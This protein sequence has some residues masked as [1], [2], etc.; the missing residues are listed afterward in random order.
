MSSRLLLAVATVG[1][2]SV[3]PAFAEVVLNRGNVAEPGTLDPQKYSTTYE[4]EISHELFEGLLTVGADAKPVP[5]GAESWTVSQDGRI[6]TFKLRSG[7]KWS[8]GK[9][10]TAND[11]VYGIRRGLDPATHGWYGNLAYNIKNA[12]RVNKGELP[13]TALGVTAPDANTVVIELNHPSPI[14]FLLLTLP[15]MAAAPKH[16]IDLHP[17]DWTKPGTMVSNGAYTL[18]EWRPNDHIKLLRNPNFHDAQH[19][20]IDVVNYYPTDDDAAAVKRLRAGELD[21]N[22]RFPPNEIA[23]LRRILPTGTLHTS[24]SIGVMYL[25]PNLKKTPFADPR[26]RRALSLAIDRESIVGQ[27]LRNGEL[28]D[29]SLAPPTVPGYTQAT[30]GF[31]G[32][33]LADRQAE[34]RRLLAQA[35]YTPQHP[36]KFEINH[37]IGLANKRVMIAVA[38]MF[39]AIGVEVTLLGG[40]VSAHYNRLREGDFTFADAGWFGNMDPEYYTYML[41]SGSTEINYGGYSNP[42]YDAKAADAAQTMEP[43]KRMKLFREAEQMALAD[44]AI[45][46]IYIYVNRDLVAPYVKGWLDNPLDYHPSRWLYID[47]SGA[48]ATR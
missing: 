33:P 34:A 10:M 36:L 46:P 21:L 41:L 3:A 39:K 15:M 47:K 14:L 4:N 44:D 25:V 2:M 29:Y 6:Y 7:L 19:V 13:L 8:D 27:I 16:V 30:L 12:E 18:A 9:A 31:K 22:L 11:F 35:G 37:R 40:D 1:A 5:G 28:T 43:V 45:I 48:T 17:T 24:P 38:D 32:K 26:V 42:A 20:R 23:Q